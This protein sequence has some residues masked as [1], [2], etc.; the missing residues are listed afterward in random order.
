MSDPATQARASTPDPPWPDAA[1]D[2]RALAALLDVSLEA[3]LVHRRF[4]PLYVNAPF[5][6]LFG[7]ESSA[8]ALGAKTMFGL[9]EP[10]SR[11]DAA[12]AW[13]AQLCAG[14]TRGERWMRRRD[15]RAI[16]TR[17]IARP[18][19][20]RGD[21][22][23]ALAMHEHAAPRRANAARCVLVN[24]ADE[25][26]VRLARTLLSPLCRQVDCAAG[27]DEAAARAARRR[28]DL[29]FADLDLPE[30]QGWRTATRLRALPAPFGA[31]PIVAMAPRSGPMRLAEIAAAG[32]DGFVGKPLAPSEIE[33]ALGLLTR[34]VEPAELDQVEHEDGDHEGYDGEERGHVQ[35][36]EP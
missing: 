14:A 10:A 1:C 35:I 19:Q 30:Q 34:S 25:G 33:R 9:I 29:V 22:A 32:M 17:F 18:M 21:A 5:A 36:S 12:R 4:A 28:Y 20:W 16:R 11:V 23:I 15:G 6:T 8:E 13:G 3:K 27:V 26:A 7:F 2:G 31:A 24:S